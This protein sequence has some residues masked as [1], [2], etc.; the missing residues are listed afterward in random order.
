MSFVKRVINVQFKVLADG[1]VTTLDLEGY[2]VELQLNSVV[3]ALAVTAMHMRI[4]GMRDTDMSQLAVDPSLGLAIKNGSIIVNAG[5]DLDGIRQVF[6]GTISQAFIDYTGVPDVA[7]DIYAV[8]GGINSALSAAPSNYPMNSDVSTIAKGLCVQ[9]GL[10]FNPK[11]NVT[12][13]TGK[14]YLSGSLN[15]QLFS[16]LYQTR[17]LGSIDKD[18][19]TIW[20]AGGISDDNISLYSPESGMVGYPTFTQTGIAV[21]VLFDANSGIGRKVSIK[22]SIPKANQT[23]YVYRIIHTL[24]T[25]TPDGAWFTDLDLTW[26]SPYVAQF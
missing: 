6:S 10:T 21:R 5:D 4:Y 7:L 18:V 15:D 24:T 19:L 25:L 26:F 8:A 20:P 16:L 23:W 11:N 9:M 12:V 14:I 22:S 13:K 1:V 3:D 2:R 17:T